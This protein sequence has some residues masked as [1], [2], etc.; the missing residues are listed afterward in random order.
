MPWRWIVYDISARHR[1]NGQGLMIECSSGPK[2]SLNCA[3]FPLVPG[4]T[5]QHLNSLGKV[6]WSTAYSK[7]CL[8]WVTSHDPCLKHLRSEVDTETLWNKRRFPKSQPFLRSCSAVVKFNVGGCPITW[9]QI[10]TKYSTRS[11]S[12]SGKLSPKRHRHW[13][14]NCY[15]QD[16]RFREKSTPIYI[17]DLQLLYIDNTS[18]I[19]DLFFEHMSDM[20]TTRFTQWGKVEGYLPTADVAFLDEIFKAPWR[21]ALVRGLV[22]GYDLVVDLSANE[23]KSSYMAHWYCWM[24]DTSS[25]FTVPMKMN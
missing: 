16:L 9:E 5:W 11:T 10:T 23:R 12:D 19:R 8:A 18:I 6:A 14:H 4:K 3:D 17:V 1:E 2:A 7:T 20:I 13:K 21:E 24:N 22:D 25:G 15:P